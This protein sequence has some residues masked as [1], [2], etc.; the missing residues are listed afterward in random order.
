MDQKVLWGL[1]PPKSRGRP[2]LNTCIGSGSQHSFSPFLLG[3]RRLEIPPVLA[4]PD[5]LCFPEGQT[6]WLVRQ[7]VNGPNRKQPTNLVSLLAQSGG[8]AA[9]LG[10]LV[11]S[12]PLSGFKLSWRFFLEL[13]SE[14]IWN[15]PWIPGDPHLEALE[16]LGSPVAPL[17]PK[18]ECKCVTPVRLCTT[19][20]PRT[21]VPVQEWLQSV[22]AGQARSFWSQ[23]SLVPQ[24]LPDPLGLQDPHVLGS[25]VHPGK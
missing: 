21:C 17:V 25:L 14:G 1:A 13:M 22:R 2:T 20:S 10:P 23:N 11:A 5:L 9:A 12:V 15:L 24:V 16:V 19:P 18:H 4:D 7:R 3:C 8:P 6:R